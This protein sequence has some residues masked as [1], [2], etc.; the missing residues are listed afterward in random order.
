MIGA[1]KS[2]VAKLLVEMLEGYEH[3]SGGDFFK[4]EASKRGLTLLELWEL[5]KEDD[6][7]H[8]NID[9]L[10]KSIKVSNV[11]LDARTAHMFHPKALS[12]YLKVDEEV[13]NKRMNLNPEQIKELSQRRAIEEKEFERLYGVDVSN[14]QEG[15]DLV[16]DTSDKE[17]YDIA[18]L[19]VKRYMEE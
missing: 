18:Y 14:M 4:A 9:E 8:R 13:R 12:V 1:G 2:T 15:M 11:I 3:V 6:T 5:S 19:I 16:I 17:P 10:I 7:V